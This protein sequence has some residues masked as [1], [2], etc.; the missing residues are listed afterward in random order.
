LHSSST[1]G[2]ALAATM[3]TGLM[4]TAQD[5]EDL[6]NFLHTLTD[7]QLEQETDYSSPF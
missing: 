7:E 2:P 4:L 1:L 3:S 6:I 5:K